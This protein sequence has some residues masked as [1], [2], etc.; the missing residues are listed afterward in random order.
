MNR[1]RWLA[2]A[3]VWL[4]SMRAGASA[5][6]TAASAPC[7]KL[8]QCLAAVKTTAAPGNGI[9]KEEVALAKAIQ[10]Y[11][12]AAVPGLLAFLTDSGPDVRALAAYTLRDL[13]GLTEAEVTPIL[14]ALRAGEQWVAP[15]LAHIGSPAAIRGLFEALAAKPQ[16]HTQVTWAFRQLGAKGVPALLGGFD[17]SGSCDPG[18]LSVLVFVFGELGGQGSVAV[19]PLM[20][21]ALDEHRPVEVRVAAVRSLGGIGPTAAAAMPALQGVAATAPATFAM[22]VQLALE[23]MKVPA[24]GAELAAQLARAPTRVLLR[25]VAEL[26]AAGASAGPVLTGLLKHDD[27]SI[28]TAAAS[29]LGHVGYRPAAGPLIAALQDHQDWQLV[30]VAAQSLGRLGEASALPALEAVARDH[31]YPPVREAA[32]KAQAVIGGSDQY[33]PRWPSNFAL[34]FLSFEHAGAKVGDCLAGSPLKNA[35]FDELQRALTALSRP[36]RQKPTTALQVEGGWLLGADR[37][38]WGGELVFVGAHGEQTIVSGNIRQLGRLGSRIIALGGLAHLTLNR[39]LV[40]ELA[41]DG[42]GKWSARPW[43]VLPG[44]PHGALPEP[45]GRWLI[46]TNGGSVLLSPDGTLAMAECPAARPVR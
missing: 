26:G 35:N 32:R 1:S 43:R 33:R 39:G 24:A 18:L 22:P 38:E 15:A 30:Y 36:I 20:A 45:G 3:I 34:E 13:Q 23:G 27:W 25:K 41:R 8:E 5:G 29:A 42:R 46:H 44:A 40:Y 37:G 31:W 28:R 7:E 14:R 19:D 9:T 16:T 10:G 21:I 17:C 6:A 4:T 11:G 12:R 2:S